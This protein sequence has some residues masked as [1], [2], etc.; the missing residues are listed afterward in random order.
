MTVPMSMM[1]EWCALVSDVLEHVSYPRELMCCLHDLYNT[2]CYTVNDLVQL[3]DGTS[4]NQGRVE[5]YHNGQWGTV[6]DDHFDPIDGNIVCQQLGYTRLREYSEGS[7]ATM[8]SGKIW[9]DDVNCSMSHVRLSDC[10]SRGW[11]I[12]D[13]VPSDDVIV[14]CEGDLYV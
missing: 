3:A 5:I 14:M 12:T 11:G 1:L 6:C 7:P 2:T 9:L 10:R 8:G 4:A 13:C